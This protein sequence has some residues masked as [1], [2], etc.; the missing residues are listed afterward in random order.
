MSGVDF[1]T[2]LQV[3]AL[4]VHFGLSQILKTNVYDFTS[5]VHS[6]GESTYPID[7]VILNPVRPNLIF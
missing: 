7:S 3:F 4:S 2:L 5:R 1:A 6:S